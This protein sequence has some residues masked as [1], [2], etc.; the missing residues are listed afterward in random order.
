M[1]ATASA[2]SY[3][4]LWDAEKLE[5]LKS[6]EGHKEWVWD[7][8]FSSDGA[9]LVTGTT[10]DRLSNIFCESYLEQAGLIQT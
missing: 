7:C 6:L 2:D 10:N 5:E 8:A 1:F 9:Y 4:G 3:V